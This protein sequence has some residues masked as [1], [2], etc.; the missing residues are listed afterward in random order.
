MELYP[1]SLRTTELDITRSR[2]AHEYADIVSARLTEYQDICF[3]KVDVSVIGDFACQRWRQ[4]QVL[5]FMLIL[6]NP[7]VLVESI[8]KQF[9]PEI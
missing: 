9:L 5:H 1:W 7:G 2:Q 3:E 8:I 6:T 4:F